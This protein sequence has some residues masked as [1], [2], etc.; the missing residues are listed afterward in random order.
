MKKNLAIF[1]LLTFC[2]FVFGEEKLSPGQAWRKASDSAKHINIIGLKAGFDYC[3]LAISG[4]ISQ[5]EEKYKN[6]SNDA[7]YY[8]TLFYSDLKGTVRALNLNDITTEQFVNGLNKFYDD[9]ANDKI[10]AGFLVMLITRRAR[11]GDHKRGGRRRIDATKKGRQKNLLRKYKIYREKKEKEIQ[12]FILKQELKN[13][14][15]DK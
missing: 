2:C 3:G 12:E 13:I 5:D 4:Q 1:M 6:L 11:G 9:Y 10:S 8:W 14:K 7:H 15:K